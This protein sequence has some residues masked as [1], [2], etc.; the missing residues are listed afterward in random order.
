MS[1]AGG[2]LFHGHQGKSYVVESAADDFPLI[3]RSHRY[4]PSVTFGFGPP[5]HGGKYFG[6]PDPQSVSVKNFQGS[7]LALR[8]LIVFRV[9]LPFEN[10]LQG[11]LIDVGESVGDES[12]GRLFVYCI[13]A[14]CRQLLF[15]E[16]PSLSQE[17]EGVVAAQ[18]AL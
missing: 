12:V 4:L 15:V 16:E 7:W 14:Q 10:D 6:L 8:F 11:V 5:Q 9:D 2:E 17:Q 18:I 1:G 3:G 13:E